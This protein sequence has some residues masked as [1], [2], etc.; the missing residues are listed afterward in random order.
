MSRNTVTKNQG[1]NPRKQKNADNKKKINYCK[2]NN[3][4]EK[5]LYKNKKAEK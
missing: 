3:N 4:E 2:M 1:G 5:D